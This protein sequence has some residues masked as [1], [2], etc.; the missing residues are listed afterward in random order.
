MEGLAGKLGQLK[1]AADE[2]EA[3]DR[4]E[5]KLA[6]WDEVN[7]AA[8]EG[9]QVHASGPWPVMLAWPAVDGREAGHMTQPGYLMWRKLSAASE[10]EELL[11]AG[12]PEELAAGIADGS[13]PV[14]EYGNEAA[15]G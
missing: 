4:L 14:V 3:G 9:W 13:I 7:P 1:A 6:L 5:Y 10:A 2:I 8:R 11:R 15:G 12:V